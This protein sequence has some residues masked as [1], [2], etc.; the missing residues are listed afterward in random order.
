MRWFLLINR[1]F[2]DC[3]N[4]Y[5]STMEQIYSSDNTPFHRRLKTIQNFFA[6]N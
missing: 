5:R 3:K 2:T 6:F 4:D 1:M